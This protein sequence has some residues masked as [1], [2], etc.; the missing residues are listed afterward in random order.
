MVDYYYSDGMDT[1]GPYSIDQLKDKKLSPDTLVWHERLADWALLKD[2]PEVITYHSMKSEPP[3]LPV[4]KERQKKRKQELDP[5]KAGQGRAVYLRDE[6]III[7]R[8]V[9][10]WLMIWTFFHIFAL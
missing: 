8:T 4:G 10:K 9:V 5:G 6:E 7:S 1:F 3:P 2:L